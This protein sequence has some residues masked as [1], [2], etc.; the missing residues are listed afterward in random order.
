MCTKNNTAFLID[1]LN[2]PLKRL[3]NFRLPFTKNYHVLVKIMFSGLCGSQIME[4][5][6]KR[7]KDIYLPH[8]LGHE[9]FAKVIKV[10]KKVKKVKKNDFVLLSWIKGKGGQEKEDGEEEVEEEERMRRRK[11]EETETKRT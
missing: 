11:N 8:L 3:R 4:M 6:G 9:G 10:G 2:K 1:K 5:Y 7:G